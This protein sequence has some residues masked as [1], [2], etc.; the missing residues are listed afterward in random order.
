MLKSFLIVLETLSS[1]SSIFFDFS[2]QA[3]FPKI[4]KHVNIKKSMI[5]SATEKYKTP[6]KRS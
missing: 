4:F 6:N 2:N 5:F 1:V 3:K